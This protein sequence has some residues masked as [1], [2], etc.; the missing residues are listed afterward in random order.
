[1]KSRIEGIVPAVLIATLCAAPAGAMNLIDETFDSGTLESTEW[2]RSLDGSGRNMSLSFTTDPAREGHKAVKL[3]LEVPDRNFSVLRNELQLRNPNPSIG[4]TGKEYTYTFSQFVPQDWPTSDLPIEVAQFHVEGE[5]GEAGRG[6]VLAFLIVDGKYK[7]TQRW[8]NKRIVRPEDTGKASHFTSLAKDQWTDWRVNV[9]WSWGDPDEPEGFLRIWKNGTLVVNETGPN[10]YND[11]ASRYF[12]WG[13]YT[14]SAWARGGSFKADTYTLYVD[15]M[16]VIAGSDNRR[17]A[18]TARLAM[19]D[20]AD[21]GIRLAITN[22]SDSKADI[23][24][25]TFTAEGRKFDHI[26]VGNGGISVEPFNALV[27]NRDLRANHSA[28]INFDEALAPGTTRTITGVGLDA[29]NGRDTLDEVTVHIVYSNGR[30]LTGKM[31][32]QARDNWVF[33]QAN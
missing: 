10:C 5:E 13:L 4:D 23:V 17:V 19:A 2:S 8:S 22:S 30:T 18:A 9:R 12:K 24:K 16:K 29:G 1:M 11:R 21:S 7:I 26:P 14:R 32:K 3:T 33:K 31:A 20:K 25:A 15:Q 6:P 28:S 27:A